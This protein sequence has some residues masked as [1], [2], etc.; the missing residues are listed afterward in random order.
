MSTLPG[1]QR[2]HT[3]S[4]QSLL[5]DLRRQTPVGAQEETEAQ[6]RGSR[7]PK[8]EPDCRVGACFPPPDS[9]PQAPTALPPPGPLPP[10]GRSWPCLPTS[11]WLRAP[12]ASGARAAAGPAVRNAIPPL[13]GTLKVLKVKVLPSALLLPNCDRQIENQLSKCQLTT[14]QHAEQVTALRGV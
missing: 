7:S 13:P 3:L 1:T 5:E 4:P 12:V 8:P 6:G 10:P 11:L 2:R 9:W 14:N